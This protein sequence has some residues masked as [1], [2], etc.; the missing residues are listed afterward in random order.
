MHSYGIERLEELIFKNHGI[1]NWRDVEFTEC[2]VLCMG[3]LHVSPTASPELV[4]DSIQRML[5][6]GLEKSGYLDKRATGSNSRIHHN[7]FA[8]KVDLGPSKDLY[9]ITILIVDKQT[10]PTEWIPSQSAVPPKH[11]PFLPLDD[12][13]LLLLPQ[14]QRKKRPLKMSRSVDWTPNC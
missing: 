6:E 4:G 11:V 8:H 5:D 14:K 7:P 2:E 3:L 1:K 12:L 10:C 13:D 9:L